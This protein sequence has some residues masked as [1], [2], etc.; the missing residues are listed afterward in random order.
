MEVTQSEAKKLRELTEQIDQIKRSIK[1]REESLEGE[2]EKGRQIQAT[3]NDKEEALIRLRETEML[4]EE[5]KD[6]L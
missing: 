5:Q 1:A 4:L 6:E 3:I 2:E